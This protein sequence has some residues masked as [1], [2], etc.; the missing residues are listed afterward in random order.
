MAQGK[1]ET[2]ADRPLAILH[3]FARHVIDGRDMIGIDRV[4]QTESI[5]Q[6][7]RP[8]QHR[9]VTEKGQSPDPNA[10]IRDG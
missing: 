1:K 8:K 3:Q 7:C 9:L 10:D 6:Q 2:D 4:P 5:R